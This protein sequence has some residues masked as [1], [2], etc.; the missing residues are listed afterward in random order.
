MKGDSSTPP[1]VVG[2]GGISRHGVTEVLQ[3]LL[4][5]PLRGP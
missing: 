3:L 2:R 4:S 1:K 5:L